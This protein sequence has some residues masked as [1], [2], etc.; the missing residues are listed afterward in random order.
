MK[1]LSLGLVA[2]LVVSSSALAQAPYY[3][4][5]RPAGTYEEQRRVSPPPR[6]E[7]LSPEQQ[8]D[9]WYRQFLNRPADD[10]AYNFWLNQVNQGSSMNDVLAGILGSE[11]FFKLQGNSNDRFVRSIYTGLLGR[12]PTPPE[13]YQA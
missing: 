7:R 4:P 1:R 5:P 6:Y 2:A 10:I 11:E 8:I 3:P 12:E 9:A 13:M